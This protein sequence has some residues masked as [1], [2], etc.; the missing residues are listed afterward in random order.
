MEF[1]EFATHSCKEKTEHR[2]WAAAF[3]HSS[4][5]LGQGTSL[6]IAVPACR[7]VQ[8]PKPEVSWIHVCIVV[9]SGD[10]QRDKERLILLLAGPYRSSCAKGPGT[11]GLWEPKLGFIMPQGADHRVQRCA[12]EV[13]S[14]PDGFLLP[15]SVRPQLCLALASQAPKRQLG[16]PN[17]VL[18]PWTGGLSLS[19]CLLWP[20]SL[21]IKEPTPV[22][23]A[24]L[25]RHLAGAWKGWLCGHRAWT[26]WG[27]PAT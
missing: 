10:S 27:H 24:L 3:A 18:R 21:S 7:T 23:P 2:P 17:P 8:N 16:S 19:S 26:G 20:W 5:D 12:S 9:T 13:S 6:S 4:R 22:W 15:A 25:P 14:L 1:P 11:P